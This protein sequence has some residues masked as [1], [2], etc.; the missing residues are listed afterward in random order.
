MFQ[1]TCRLLYVATRYR[2]VTC[3]RAPVVCC[4]SSR[5]TLAVQTSYS[6][7]PK[8]CTCVSSSPTPLSRSHRSQHSSLSP[9]VR[10]KIAPKCY[11]LQLCRH[12]VY[13]T[14]VVSKHVTCF[15]WIHCTDHC[16]LY[17]Q[18]FQIE[19]KVNSI[20]MSFF[21]Q[22]SLWHVRTLAL[23]ILEGKSNLVVTGARPTRHGYNTIESTC[24]CTYMQ[25]SMYMYGLI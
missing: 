15:R 6:C 25:F 23:I 8:R 4:T 5:A 10:A 21:L 14:P 20:L 19:H 17:Y 22:K 9:G 13:A 12:F 16:L 2:D 1:G 7:F 18:V 11:T 24:T 3:F